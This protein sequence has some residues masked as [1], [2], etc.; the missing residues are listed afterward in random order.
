MHWAYKVTGIDMVHP[1]LDGL[2]QNRDCGVNVA[3]RS[4]Y[5]PAGQLHR[6]V[7]NQPG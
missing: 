3:M 2:A 1:R 5:L 7:F 4:P 6:V